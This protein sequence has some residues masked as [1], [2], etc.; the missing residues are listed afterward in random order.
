MKISRELY[1]NYIDS[2]PFRLGQA[3]TAWA[4]EHPSPNEQIVFI[5]SEGK[6]TLTPKQLADE[7]INQTPF[8]QEQ[9]S[10]Y[11]D[12]SNNLGDRTGDRVIKD[13]SNCWKS[14]DA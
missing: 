1:S 4:E 2:F 5:S 14:T 12:I 8:G 9:T 10:F 13:L 3:L 7:V 6:R 11:W